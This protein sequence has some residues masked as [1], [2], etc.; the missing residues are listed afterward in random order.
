MDH[1]PKVIRHP[2]ITSRPV[3]LHRLYFAQLLLRRYSKNSAE[4]VDLLLKLVIQYSPFQIH[5]CDADPDLSVVSM[6]VLSLS[7]EY[8][9]Y[10]SSDEFLDDL[11]E[12]AS[13]GLVPPLAPI[14]LNSFQ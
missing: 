3:D 2:W 12:A 7:R 6:L 11:Q 8:I 13:P 1:L 10:F 5:E 9:H 14:P 4:C